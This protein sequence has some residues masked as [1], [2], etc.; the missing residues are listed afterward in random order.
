MVNAGHQGAGLLVGRDSLGEP[1]FMMQYRVMDTGQEI[2]FTSAG[3][4]ALVVDVRLVFCPWCGRNLEKWYR[5][6]ID[7]LYRPH[8]KIRLD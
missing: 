3:P 2:D 5:N 1:E 7:D 8:L 6:I 4:I